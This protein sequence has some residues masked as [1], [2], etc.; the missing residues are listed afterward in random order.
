MNVVSDKKK[1]DAAKKKADIVYKRPSAY[2]SGFIVKKY[3]EMGG[4]F[5]SKQ[6]TGRGLKRWFAEKWVNQRGEVGYKYKSDV[7]RPSKRVTSS[8]PATWKELSSARS[9]IK[10]EDWS[11]YAISSKEMRTVKHIFFVAII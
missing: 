2:K 1:W 6:S 5:S 3:K 8:T 4:K 7:Y 11:S 10:I 9:K